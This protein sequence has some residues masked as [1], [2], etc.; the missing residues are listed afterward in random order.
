MF[1]KSITSKLRIWDS[2][3]NKTGICCSLISFCFQKVFSENDDFGNQTRL[4]LFSTGM[5]NDTIHEGI[6]NII[7]Y[8]ALDET[9]VISFINNIWKINLHM[10]IIRFQVTVLRSIHAALLFFSIL[11]QITTMFQLKILWIL[12]IRTECNEK[13]VH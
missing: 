4:M 11:L 2:M 9:L 12:Y 7:Y 10:W 5:R 3:T 6:H 8:R 13:V 1:D